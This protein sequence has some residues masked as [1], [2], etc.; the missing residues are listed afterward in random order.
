[1]FVADLRTS[2][3]LFCHRTPA[4]AAEYLRW[5]GRRRHHDTAVRSVLKFRGSLAQAAP[6][7]L[8]ELT[9]TTLIPTPRDGE[10]HHRRVLE[11]PFDFIDHEFLPPSPAQGPFFELLVHA[12]QHGLLLI[13]R[14][15]DHA[16]SFYSEGREHGEDCFTISL[17]D[18]ER[19]FPWRKSYAWSR[20]GSAAPYCVTSALMALESWGHRRIDAGESFERVLPDVLGPPGSPAAYLLVVVDLLLSHWPKS[21][22][23]ALPYLACPKL[24]CIDRQRLAHDNFEYPDLLGLKALEKEPAG[25]VTKDDL[26]KRASRRLMLDQV[27]ADYAVAGPGE[28][29]EKLVALLRRA[30]TRLG[31]PDEQSDLGDPPFMAVHALNSLDP[32][33][34]RKVTVQRGDGTQGEAWE[35][36]SPPDEDRHLEALREASR[37]RFSDANMRAALGVAMQDTSRSSPELVAAGVEWAKRAATMPKSDDADEDRMRQEAIAIAAMI[38]MRDGDAALRTRYEAWARS[39]FAEAFQGKDDPAYRFRSGLRFNPVAIAF[40]GMTHVAKIDDLVGDMRG[41]LE[42]ATREEPA[43]AHGF[44]VVAHTLASLDERLPRAVL[45]CAFAAC[46]RPRREWD[47]AKD[48]AAARAE[49]QLQRGRAAVDAELSWLANE[50][51]EPDWPP[52]SPEPVRRRRHLSVPG[53]RSQQDML[54]VEPPQPEEYTDHQAAA[55]WLSNTKVLFDVVKRPWLRDVA[56]AYSPWTARANGA[57][58]DEG[59]GITDAPG[60]WNSA[61]FDLLAHCLPGLEFAEVDALALATIVSLPDEPFFDVMTQFLRCVD[62]VYFNSLGLQEPIAIGV[63]TGVAQRLM[64]SDG[65]NRLAASLSHSIER[66]IASAVATLFFND[67]GFVQPT[68][69]YLLPKGADRIDAFLPVLEELVTHGPCLFVA[70]VVLNLVEVSPKATHLPFVLT[71]ANAWLKS[72]PDRNDF[73]IGYDIGRRVSLWIEAVWRGEPTLLVAE[74]AVRANVD[75]LLAALVSLGIADAR[76]LEEALPEGYQAGRKPGT[77][78]A[79]EHGSRR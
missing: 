13:R 32:N 73:W 35:Y 24:L 40:V 71:A 3:L 48:Q 23:A 53:V 45:R 46:I 14:L 34:W 64:A 1:L 8:A 31:P 66:H 19:E 12:P 79:W 17:A 29:Q 38:A 63:R 4:L 47:L 50:R 27:L 74:R 77:E 68:K 10:R 55:V 15:V 30:A 69:C 49:R 20:E 56:R 60:E 44:G 78:R 11:K 25:A 21:R 61:Y 70:L 7:E 75:R 33:N 37:D 28:L 72:Y 16:V 59:E 65:W 52:F 22:E 18:G 67:H 51:G 9:A 76:R 43:A 2:F 6:A 57:G 41:L 5:L 42:V 26:K 36:V 39:V 58:L 54:T 62:A